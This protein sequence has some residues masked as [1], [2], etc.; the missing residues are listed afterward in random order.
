MHRLRERREVGAALPTPRRGL[1]FARREYR[2]MS[3]R[4][5]R[6]LLV[7]EAKEADGIRVG[8]AQRFLERQLA[9]DG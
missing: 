5:R 3:L 4:I 2:I 8:G 6:S 9:P 1:P 7:L